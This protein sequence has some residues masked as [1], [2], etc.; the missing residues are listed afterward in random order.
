[1]M[2]IGD[3]S[4]AKSQILRFVLN[5][6]PLS[7]NTTGI[8]LMNPTDPTQCLNPTVAFHHRILQTPLT[9]IPL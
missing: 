2:M 3:P 7:I 8:H 1:M 5:V 4:T 9:L 6:A